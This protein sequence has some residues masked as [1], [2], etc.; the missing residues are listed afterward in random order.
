MF[1]PVLK[2]WTLYNIQRSCQLKMT[3][4]SNFIKTNIT[5]YEYLKIQSGFTNQPS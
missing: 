3:L 1:I 5:P 4:E 2:F